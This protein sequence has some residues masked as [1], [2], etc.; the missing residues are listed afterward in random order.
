MNFIN[1]NNVSDY[2]DATPAKDNTRVVRRFN[3]FSQGEQTRF[4]KLMGRTTKVRDNFNHDKVETI[5]AIWRTIRNETEMAVGSTTYILVDNDDFFFWYEYQ[6]VDGKWYKASNH[7]RSQNGM[8]RIELSLAEAKD[9]TS[10]F[11]Y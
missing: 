11:N 5:N 2:V 7:E 1:R 4:T 10:K 3:E 6:D 8:T 9:G